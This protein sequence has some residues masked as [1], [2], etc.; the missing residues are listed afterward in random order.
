MWWQVSCRQFNSCSTCPTSAVGRAGWLSWEVGTLTALDS[1]YR[2]PGSLM[3]HS[4][5]THPPGIPP[6]GL[7]WVAWSEQL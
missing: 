7:P 1:D 2:P 3:A 4:S 6:V 5:H